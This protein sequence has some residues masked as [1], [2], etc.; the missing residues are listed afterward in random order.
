MRSTPETVLDGLSL[1]ATRFCPP[2]QRCRYGYVGLGM[3][4]HHI[5][6]KAVASVPNTSVMPFDA[7]P[8]EQRTKFVLG[9]NFVVQCAGA[10]ALRFAPQCKLSELT[11][12]QRRC[13]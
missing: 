2:A 6:R 4:E 10:T 11:I 13:D 7:M 5:N 1:T 12:A 3:S 8:P 9:S